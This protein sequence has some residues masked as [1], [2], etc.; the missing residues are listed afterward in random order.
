[1]HNASPCWQC[2]V[3][4]CINIIL[5]MSHSRN[6]WRP[7]RWRFETWKWNR[8]CYL[9]IAEMLHGKLKKC[10][11]GICGWCGL[12]SAQCRELLLIVLFVRMPIF[13]H[14]W[15][16]A[17]TIFVVAMLWWHWMLDM[18]RWLS[19]RLMRFWTGW[20][21]WRIVMWL[22]WMFSIVI[23]NVTRNNFICGTVMPM[24]L[25]LTGTVIVN[26]IIVVVVVGD[27]RARRFG[28]HITMNLSFKPFNRNVQ[29]LSS[30]SCS[31]WNCRCLRLNLYCKRKTNKRKQVNFGL[32][33][34]EI[35]VECGCFKN[36]IKM[37][38]GR[39]LWIF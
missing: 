37:L 17:A 11:L 28:P 1:M 14:W 10:I 7:N 25:V 29:C 5:S 19:R 23:F 36:R 35:S 39:K 27:W 8:M 30:G 22:R 16:A 34:I 9:L 13:M 3:L 2:D 33:L 32:L 31:R 26:V 18:L 20:L 6:I 38:N 12:H 15:H 21:L 24:L 4:F